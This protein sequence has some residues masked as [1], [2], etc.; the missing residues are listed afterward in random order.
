MAIPPRRVVSF[1][2]PHD[3]VLLGEGGTVA[4]R[5]RFSI[6]VT[7]RGIMSIRSFRR[8]DSFINTM[9]VQERSESY[10]TM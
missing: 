4:F 3:M 1:P 7:S 10:L 8:A 9:N 5:I 6:Q 2:S